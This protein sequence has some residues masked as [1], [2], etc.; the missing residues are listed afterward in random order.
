MM[1]INLIKI[2]THA[3]EGPL[4][5]TQDKELYKQARSK[6]LKAYQNLAINPRA[7]TYIRFWL[8]YQEKGRFL[9]AWEFYQKASEVNPQ[10]VYARNE[11]DRLH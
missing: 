5:D 1:D 9:K 2:Y 6:I 11:L 3:L 7:S 4:K 8:Y 10:Y